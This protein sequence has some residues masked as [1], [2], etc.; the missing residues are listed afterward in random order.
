MRVVRS[1]AFAGTPEFAATILRAIL[2]AGYAVPLVLTQPDRPAGRG[3]RLTPSPVKAVAEAA[4]IAVWQPDRLKT[5]KAWAP[6]VA[7]AQPDVL[8]VAA[9]GLILPQALLAWPR[10]GA[11]N[12]H[13]SLLP[14]WRGA[15]PVARAIE[16]GDT[17]TGITVMQMDE[18]LDTGAILAQYPLA[19][20]P[21]ATTGTLTAQLA[22]L[23]AQAIVEVLSDLPAYQAR[24]VPQPPEGVTYAAKVTPAER[25]IDWR[26]PAEV[27][28]RRLRAFDPTPGMQTVWREQPWK[29]W[30]GQ[31]A[32]EGGRGARGDSAGAEPGTVVAVDPRRGILVACG[33]GLLWLTELQRAGGKRLPVVEFLRGAAVEVG[34][35]LGDT[36]EICP[37]GEPAGRA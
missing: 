15:A 31:V 36:P 37:P 1:L 12:L 29:V 35:R 7:A 34:D 21:Q 22:D 28:E 10:L 6:I 14:R 32:Q 13:A 8:V 18:G 5:P 3:M 11:V 20:D 19:I 27:L 17:T 9:Y 24:A 2:A 30:R 23:A 26:Q 16:A 4:G 25:T 33:E